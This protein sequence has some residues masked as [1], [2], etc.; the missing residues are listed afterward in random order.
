MAKL[1]D[2]EFGAKLVAAYRGYRD[3]HDAG[4]LAEDAEHPR[5][6]VNNW[7]G[8]IRDSKAT[9]E[10]S[11]LGRVTIQKRGTPNE[12]QALDNPPNFAGKPANP[13]LGKPAQDSAAAGAE[14]D[15]I[16]RSGHHDVEGQLALASARRSNP[17]RVR[18]MEN[19]IPALRRLK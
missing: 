14:D 19:A 6:T 18:A 13:T 1:T 7:L 2:D 15:M 5:D 11:G 4:A 9:D 17:A 16:R 10:N 3:L 12:E 8:T